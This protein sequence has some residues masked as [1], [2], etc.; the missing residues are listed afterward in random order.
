M[1][2][3]SS[4]W[5]QGHCQELETQTQENGEDEKVTAYFQGPVGKTYT[6]QMMAKQDTYNVS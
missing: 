2:F 1:I 6:F 3:S 4:S 5:V